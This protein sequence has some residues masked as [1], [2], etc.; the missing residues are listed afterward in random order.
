[1]NEEQYTA[2]IIRVLSNEATENEKQRLESWLQLK[3]ENR[4]LYLSFEESWNQTGEENLNA[5]F[6]KDA[7]WADIEKKFGFNKTGTGEKHHIPTAS[8]SRRWFRPAFAAAAA[9]VLIISA[10]YF[11]DLLQDTASKTFVNDEREVQEV[12]LEDGS[13]AILSTGSKLV[14]GEPFSNSVRNVF[15]EGRVFFNVVKDDR[16]FI[17]ATPNARVE[18]L[19]TQFEVFS[20]DNR[21]TVLV[22]EGKVALAN[23]E[24]PAESVV[25][26]V[27]EKGECR[28]A[29]P[30]EKIDRVNSKALISWINGNIVFHRHTLKEIVAELSM[31]YDVKIVIEDQSLEPLSLHAVF[32]PDETVNQIINQISIAL[33]LNISKR[34]KVFYISPK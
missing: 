28:E 15:V 31:L 22:N 25:L 12:K 24:L 29:Q 27:N 5:S 14:I 23:S 32:T 3:Q 13:T 2:L 26:E 20:R 11:T 6:D 16:K 4:E 30:A 21:T 10:F 18:V 17:A 19:G 9:C 7:G 33:N 34:D 8:F 1:M